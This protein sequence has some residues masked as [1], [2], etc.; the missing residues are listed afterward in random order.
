MPVVTD[1]EEERQGVVDGYTGNCI[2]WCFNG[3]FP[4]YSIDSKPAKWWKDPDGEKFPFCSRC[5][6]IFRGTL[7]R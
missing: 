7:D 5:G 6:K 3:Q 1:K 2:W 4:A